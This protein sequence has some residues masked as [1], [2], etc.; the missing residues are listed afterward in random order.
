MCSMPAAHLMQCILQAHAHPQTPCLGVQQHDLTIQ[1]HI[2]NIFQ[3][4]ALRFEGGDEDATQIGGLP[5]GLLAPSI[6]C[7]LHTR[8]RMQGL[9]KY[10]HWLQKSCFRKV[11]AR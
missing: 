11:L 1:H 2:V 9:G 7:G 4:A 8:T 3:V 5:C 10:A 6:I